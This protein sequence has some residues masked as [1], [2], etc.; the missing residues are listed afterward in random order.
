MPRPPTTTAGN[1]RPAPAQ[2]V[3]SALG[4]GALYCFEDYFVP[5]R[6]YGPCIIYVPVGTYLDCPAK[7]YQRGNYYGVEIDL[8]PGPQ[9]LGVTGA[10]DWPTLF[11]RDWLVALCQDMTLDLY[12][13]QN[14]SI[15]LTPW[16]VQPVFGSTAEHFSLAFDQSARPV[17]AWQES[18]GVHVRQFDEL[19]GHYVFSGP[20]DG[21]DPTLLDD[22]SVMYDVSV[23]DVILFYLSTDR[24]HL[25]YRIQSENYATEH[26]FYDFAQ[27]VVVD[28]VD[29]LVYR[30]QVKYALASGDPDQSSSVDQALRSLLYPV[31]VEDDL[32]VKTGPLREGDYALVVAAHT[33]PPMAATALVGILTDGEYAMPIL[34]AS[35]AAG[36]DA[37]VGALPSGV[38]T[39]VVL[40]GSGSDAAAASIAAIPSADYILTIF[41]QSLSEGVDGTITTLGDGSY[42]L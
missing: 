10:G 12:Q 11:S 33:T 38:L 16:D 25:N 23:S 15:E 9:E 34:T 14:G 28:A 1:A 21:T 32:R 8:A 29:P 18:D 20:Y 36:A 37:T 6:D 31:E 7:L 3:V 26:S 19:L 4:R 41:T 27:A 30:Y 2:E 22:A 24:L 42:T 17:I 39:V 5:I 13:V 35:G 40:T